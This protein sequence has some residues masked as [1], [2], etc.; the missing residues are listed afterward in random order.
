MT[1]V[2]ISVGQTWKESVRYL[3]DI[4]HSRPAGSG[5]DLTE[6]R[7]IIDIVV[8]GRNI[9]S[10][11]DEDHVFSVVDAMVSA[12]LAI[13]EGRSHKAIVEFTREPW[14]LVFRPA[15]ECVQVSLYSVGPRRHVVA[16]QVETAPETLHDA[17]TSTAAAMLD[18]LYGISSQFTSDAFVRE[19]SDRLDRLTEAAPA[20]LAELRGAE[21]AER[22]GG[23]RRGSTSSQRGLSV[24][25]AYDADYAPLRDYA[26]EHPFDL[27]ALLAPGHVDIEWAGTPVTLAEGF[28]VLTCWRLLGHAR[29][30]LEYLETDGTQ[31][32]PTRQGRYSAVD[33]EADGRLCRFSV[34]A[35]E[36]DGS[37]DGETL[38]ATLPV[39]EAIDTL[40]SVGQ[41]FLDD[42][43]EWNP[44][45]ELNHRLEQLRREAEEL[46]NWLA[47]I[48]EE[49]TYLDDPERHIDAHA[50]IQ[51]V[52]PSDPPPAGFPHRFQET[53]RIFGRPRWTVYRPHLPPDEVAP[54][55][56]G[57]LTLTAG[58]VECL[59]WHTGERLWNVTPGDA[60]IV[61]FEVHAEGWAALEADGS[62]ALGT[63][64]AVRRRYPRLF[65]GTD[66]SDRLLGA[67]YFPRADRLVACTQHGHAVGVALESDDCWTFDAAHGAFTGAVW[68][69]GLVAMLSEEGFFY[70]VSPAD[71]DLLWKVRLG[72]LVDRPPRLHQGR[73]YAFTHDPAHRHL[74]VHAFFP[75][76]GRTVWN[77]RT[78]GLLAGEPTFIDRWLILPI[79]T[80]HA[81]ALHAIDI[82]SPQPEIEWSAELTTAGMEGVSALTPVTLS[83][84]EHGILQTD[85]GD[86]HCLNLSDGSTRWHVAGHHDSA[87][88]TPRPGPRLVDDGLLVVGRQIDVR[89]PSSGV[90]MHRVEAPVRRPQFAHVVGEL[91]LVLGDRSHDDSVDD[92][93]VGYD[94]NHFLTEV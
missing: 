88:R 49:N 19:F 45:L 37:D 24:A 73:I 78:E 33:V 17:V 94:L 84:V 30:L 58:S 5:V 75:Y 86:V 42:L 14:E 31:L 77:L 16:H 6:I 10:S 93:I 69:G 91:M 57:L 1:S 22:Q 11:V 21:T 92:R 62:L 15:G 32:Q 3:H 70:A 41:L 38:E 28:P 34:A 2:E 9:T 48:A 82:E 66:E 47:E 23:W 46:G 50:D 26:G 20:S 72:G 61:S 90:L 12:L 4:R 39:N 65:A 54:S 87:P 64:E 13:A 51:P 68:S 29:E 79:E 60:D 74:K 44:R 43:L 36:P 55:A 83:G 8:D 25:Y 71:G 35:S 63:G 40:V 89:A 85:R 53:Y 7:D 18:D 76:T 52:A 81:T 67:A 80:S 56:D 27:H 59:D